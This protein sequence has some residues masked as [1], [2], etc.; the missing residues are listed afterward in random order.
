MHHLPSLPTVFLHLH[1]PLASH[2]FV[3]WYAPWF[4]RTCASKPGSVPYEEYNKHKSVCSLTNT[5]PPPTSQCTTRL[6][7]H[8]YVYVP[9][10]TQQSTSIVPHFTLNFIINCLAPHRHQTPP[11]PTLSQSQCVHR[12]FL[13]EKGSCVKN[14][15]FFNFFLQIC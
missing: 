14:L 1:T 10:R 6:C 12:R 13:E 15:F 2:K 4:S 11:T 3:R 8:P 9:H 5:L 7:L